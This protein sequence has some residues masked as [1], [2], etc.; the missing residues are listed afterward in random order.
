MTRKSNIIKRKKTDMNDL[1]DNNS[2]IEDNKKNSRDSSDI[3]DI[4]DNESLSDAFNYD[5]K[6]SHNDNFDNLDDEGQK[7]YLQ[8]VVLDR[9]VKYIKIDDI[10]KKKT[11]RV[12]ERNENNKRFQRSIGA[13]FNRLSR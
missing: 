10:I 6:K 7:E 5:T 12:Q 11:T 4:G 3:S 1:E 9:V 2:N 8:T 13:I